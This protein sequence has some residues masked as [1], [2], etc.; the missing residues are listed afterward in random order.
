MEIWAKANLDYLTY[1]PKTHFR[2]PDIKL[3]PRGGWSWGPYGSADL[4]NHL[5]REVWEEHWD[6]EAA[7]RWPWDQN[8]LKTKQQIKKD[9]EE[10]IKKFGLAHYHL[11]K[12][13]PHMDKTKQE[14][15]AL[16]LHAG[17]LKEKKILELGLDENY[18]EIPS[19]EA[20]SKTYKR[21][22]KAIGGKDVY[23]SQFDVWLIKVAQD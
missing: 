20:G 10:Y 3:R 4:R 18:R 13:I 12:E 15:E 19:K 8:S 5:F 23:L 11:Q 1:H 17:L 16:N 22:I 21:E 9:Q 6:A 7:N 2:Y 14:E